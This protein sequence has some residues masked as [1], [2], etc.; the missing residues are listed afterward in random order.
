MATKK[1][2]S[3]KPVAKKATT[4]KPA[5]AKKAPAKRTTTVRA[6]TAP[7]R[8]WH[9]QPAGNYKTFKASNDQQ[10]FKVRITDQTIY[11]AILGFIVLALGVWV[12]TIND[13][14]QYLYDQIDAQNAETSVEAPAVKKAE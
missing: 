14:V 10:F 6:K 7:Q 9:V 13:K 5:V 4:K 12:I 11:W 3:K 1:P 2:V 8:A